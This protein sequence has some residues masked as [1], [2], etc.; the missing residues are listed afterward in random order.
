MEFIR[1]VICSEIWA[2]RIRQTSRANSK[3]KK[4][5]WLETKGLTLI[6]ICRCQ[7][8]DDLRKT[9]HKSWK[10]PTWQKGH[11]GDYSTPQKPETQSLLKK[12][13]KNSCTSSW[14]GLVYIP[15]EGGDGLRRDASQ[16]IK[17][18]STNKGAGSERPP[19]LPVISL[20]LHNIVFVNVFQ[21]ESDLSEQHGPNSHDF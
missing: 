2:Q 6:P 13:Q 9:T 12:K 19:F 17:D 21:M 3:T 18:R 8:P 4:K 15:V 5:F 11:R 20:A 7:H 16:K 14:A 1:F 10:S